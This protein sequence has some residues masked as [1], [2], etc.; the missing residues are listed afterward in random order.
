MGEIIEVH[1]LTRLKLLTSIIGGLI[2]RRKGIL[3]MMVVL[4]CIGTA[5]FSGFV[6][7]KG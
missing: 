5:S 4:I 3:K 6:G 2:S 7:M 1:S